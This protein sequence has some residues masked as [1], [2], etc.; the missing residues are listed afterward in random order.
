MSLGEALNVLGIRTIHN[1]H[2]AVT[3]RELRRGEYRLSI[4]RNYQG[5]VDIPVA[6]YFPQLDAAFPRSKFIL[7]VREVESW[8]ASVR[9]H[10]KWQEQAG[11]DS[12]LDFIHAAVYGAIEFSDERY[13]YVFETHR[14][15]VEHY[16]H[17]RPDDLLVIDIAAGDAWET[18]CPFLGVPVPD[19]PFPHANTREDIAQWARM[20]EMARHDLEETISSRGRVV[21][22]DEGKL[23]GAIVDARRA[24]PFLERDGVY[25]GLPSDS[26]EAIESL[27]RLRRCGAEH[28]VFVWPAFWWLDHYEAFREYL[29]ARFR[30]VR[31]TE[32]VVVFDLRSG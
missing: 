6:P 32:A 22:V 28:L 27:E 7:T 30:C 25:F 10:W 20:I 29:T 16:F 21:V 18:L 11:R 2:D 17:D 9:K 4:C 15:N 24:W 8:L 13:R 5:V 1:P 3:E 14:R 12:F 19:V 31:E 23:G 26:V